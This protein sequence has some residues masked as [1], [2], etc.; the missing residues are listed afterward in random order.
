[1]MSKTSF[2]NL[3]LLLMACSMIACSSKHSSP[4]VAPIPSV[5]ITAANAL[6]VSRAALHAAFGLASV[7]ASGATVLNAIPPM[8]TSAA[9]LTTLV[10][11]RLVELTTTRFT[12]PVLLTENL[13]GQG[14][15]HVLR[16]IDDR[17]GNQR[18]STGDEVAITFVGYAENAMTLDGTMVLDQI[19]VQGDPL[20]GFTWIIACRLS[21]VNLQVALGDITEVVNGSLRCRIE[22]RA[23]V[24]ILELQIE[25]GL[26]VGGTTLMP[27]NTLTYNRYSL[28]YS[29]AKFARGAVLDQAVG[30]L[31]LFETKEPFTGPLG[32]PFSGAGVMKV[33]G[34]GGSRIVITVLDLSNVEIAVD[35]DGDGEVDETRVLEWSEL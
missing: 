29:V 5:E 35:A 9:S 18:V 3:P 15:G 16:T 26:A 1:M 8:T 20:E 10:E 4:E 12:L 30:G 7:A 14:S 11:Y 6:D 32:Y 33:R 23:T 24:A 2:V 31:V 17:D 13:P 27:G 22:K 28:D 25:A 34:A 19:T 21:F